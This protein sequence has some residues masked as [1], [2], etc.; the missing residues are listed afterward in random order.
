MTKIFVFGSNQKGIH[1]AGAALEARRSY[2][3][4]I[5]VGEGLTGRSYA[6]PTKDFNIKTRSL[7][8]INISVEKFISFAKE[9]KDMSFFVTAIGTGLAG[10]SHSEIAPMFMKSPENCELPVV[11]KSI[12]DLG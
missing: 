8:D 1:G 2:G 3:A 6:I 5:G 4:I 11:W 7:P 12:I 10:Y 9:N